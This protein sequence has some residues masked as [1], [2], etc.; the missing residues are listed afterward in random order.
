METLFY[1]ISEYIV[2]LIIIFIILFLLISYLF[3]KDQLPQF[4]FGLLKV[5]GSIF[6]SPFIKVKKITL[7]LAEFGSRGEQLHSHTSQYLLTKIIL[8][9]EAALI[10]LSI[11]ILSSGLISGWNSFLP[12]KYLRENASHLEDLVSDSKDKLSDLNSQVE[13]LDEAWQNNKTKYF[14]DVK[15]SKKDMISGL[16]S[17]NTRLESSIPVD[18][19]SK[20]ALK[21]VKQY[22]DA[23]SGITS[24]REIDEVKRNAMYYVNNNY[25][26]TED[27]RGYLRTY[28]G[29]WAEIKNTTNELNSLTEE[30]VRSENQ[31]NY[32][33]LKSQ[34]KGAQSSFDYYT[35]ELQNVKA[36]MHYNFGSLFLSILIALLTVIILVWL[37]G[38]A[39]E[40]L[41]LSVDLATNVNHLKILK[42]EE[43][44][45]S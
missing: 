29:N 28:I 3:A 11:S 41:N 9:L 5:I 26:L 21:N 34:L 24:T 15:K 19:K 30:K 31:P 33:S 16:K 39:I 6:Y 8:I 32:L 12:S 2:A 4:I 1:T 23:N 38:T 27:S 44:G 14:D 25:S 22:L 7:K 43:L 17:E 37:V 18:E 13:E 35:R 40:L 36:N 42:E 10:I 20:E 45:K